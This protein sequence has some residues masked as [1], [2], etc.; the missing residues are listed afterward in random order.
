MLQNPTSYLDGSLRFSTPSPFICFCYLQI[1]TC[2]STIDRHLP[3]NCEM[4]LAKRIFQRLNKNRFAI[5]LCGDWTLCCRSCWP[6][7]PPE[8]DSWWTVRHTGPS[9]VAQMAK[10]LP[11]VRETWVQSL[12]QEDLLEK[13]MATLSSSLAWKIPWT[14]EPGEIESMGSQRVRHHWTTNTHTSEALYAPGNKSLD[15]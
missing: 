14:E 11:S 1:G 13:G 7:T 15:S 4:S 8:G 10:S 12:G 9:L 5:C 6:L 3:D 2:L